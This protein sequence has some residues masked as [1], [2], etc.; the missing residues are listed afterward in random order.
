[1]NRQSRTLGFGSAAALVVA[2]IACAVIFSGGLGQNLAFVFVALGLVLATSLVFYEVGLTEDRER[3]SEKRARESRERQLERD[4]APK[5][6][7]PPE[8]S[9]R[10]RLD[11]MRGR[12][13][14]LR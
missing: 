8:R 13:R 1:M 7:H 3:A 2:G 10:I 14:R 5:P 9:T 12:S 4:R 6:G 11:R